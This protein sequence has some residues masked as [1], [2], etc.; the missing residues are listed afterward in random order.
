M[1]ELSM[2]AILSWDIGFLFVFCLFPVFR[3]GLLGLLIAGD[4]NGA[5]IT[6]PGFILVDLDWEPEKIQHNSL[7]WM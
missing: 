6:G 1:W 7:Q 3:V 2:P 5:H 4:G